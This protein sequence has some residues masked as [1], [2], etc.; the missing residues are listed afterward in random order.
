M[1]HKPSII[2]RR[3]WAMHSNGQ[4]LWVLWFMSILQRVCLARLPC[5]R[6]VRSV[7][8]SRVMRIRHQLHVADSE[9]RPSPTADLSF[10][11]EWRVSVSFVLSQRVMEVLAFWWRGGRA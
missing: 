7:S 3:T 1:S 10:S 8:V 6:A 11:D 9:L 2:A 4:C 5:T